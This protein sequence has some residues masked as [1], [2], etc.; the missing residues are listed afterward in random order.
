MHLFIKSMKRLSPAILLFLT[1]VMLTMTA[2]G[3]EGA[4]PTTQTAD[5]E[6]RLTPVHFT[7]EQTAA[8]QRSTEIVT[9]FRSLTDDL[10]SGK[11]KLSKEQMRAKLVEMREQIAT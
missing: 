7:P 6:R 8:M 1:S 5:P 11:S 9:Q 10:L 3:A 4:A 2:A